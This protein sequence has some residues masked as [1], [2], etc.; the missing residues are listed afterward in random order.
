L[1]YNERVEEDKLGGD[2]RMNAGGGKR[3]RRRRRRRMG[4]WWE[5]KRERDD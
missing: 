5:S 3:R 4:Y 2:C 1:N